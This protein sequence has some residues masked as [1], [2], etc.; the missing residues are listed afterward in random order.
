LLKA[1]STPGWVTALLALEPDS[2]AWLRSGADGFSD[3]E[4][5]ALVRGWRTA[6]DPGV[7]G[8]RLFR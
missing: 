1:V 6:L 4:L 2:R 5:G 3:I 7:P 8:R